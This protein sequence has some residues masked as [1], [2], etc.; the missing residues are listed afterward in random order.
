MNQALFPASASFATRAPL[1]VAHAPHPAQAVLAGRSD[2]WNSHDESSRLRRLRSLLGL[3]TL[4]G[5]A[6][7]V[8]LAV[9]DGA[10]V[11]CI[12]V[13]IAAHVLYA[14]HRIGASWRYAAWL[15]GAKERHLARRGTRRA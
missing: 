6:L 5:G 9:S 15:E 3:F 14:T 11:G 1:P 8:V 2:A 7:M 4:Y 12:L 13:G 10:D